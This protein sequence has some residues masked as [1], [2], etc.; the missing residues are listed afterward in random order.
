[1]GG[2]GSGRRG[3]KDT[4]GEMLALDIRRWTREGYLRPGYSGQWTWSRRGTAY[5]NIHYQ[6]EDGAVR[7][8]YKTR[9]RSGEW[10]EM[11]YRVRLDRTPCNYGG[12]R[13]WFLCP[14]CSRRVALIYGGKVFACRHCHRLAY[15]SQRETPDDRQGRQIDKIRD[16]LKWA[17]GLLNG[18]GRKPKWM[19]WRTFT[20]LERLHDEKMNRML[21]LV[22][23]RF[24]RDLDAFL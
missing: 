2:Y 5:A 23:R 10:Q 11:D 7:L 13:V 15:D 24:G 4:V 16:R 14:S 22:R 18:N 9:E 8:M 17:P 1:M 6:V 20:R 19:R 3:G 21:I 12:A